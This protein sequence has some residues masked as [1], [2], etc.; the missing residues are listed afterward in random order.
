MNN[1]IVIA[2]LSLVGITSSV[3]LDTVGTLDINM[4]AGT[5]FQMYS[6]LPVTSTFERDNV[7]VTAQYG[8]PDPSIKKADVS[9]VNTARLV[10]PTNGTIAGITGYAY[11]PDSDEPGKLKVHFDEGAPVDADYWVTSLGPV[12]EDNL[13]DYAI[14]SDNIGL[15]LYVLA[16]NVETFETKYDTTVREQLVDLGF[17]G[18]A[19]EPIPTY[20]KADCDYSWLV[21]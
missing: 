21:E 4:Y 13:Y 5:W 20:Q 1:I 16:R 7:C 11:V 10:Q 9:V 15:T 14:V 17:T 8:Q 6:N 19:K 3:K 2:L 18:K 12:N